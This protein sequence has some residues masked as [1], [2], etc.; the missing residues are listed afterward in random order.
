MYFVNCVLYFI[1]LKILESL[2]LLVLPRVCLVI[3]V[4]G[5]LNCLR[6]S[7]GKSLGISKTMDFCRDLHLLLPGG[8]WDIND[9]GSLKIKFLV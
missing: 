3:F 5:L 6:V 8:L 9:L 2:F 1:V 7:C 4:C